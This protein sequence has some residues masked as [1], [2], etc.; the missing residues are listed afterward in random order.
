MKWATD[1]LKIFSIYLL[2]I[3]AGVIIYSIKEREKIIPNLVE[4]F[5]EWWVVIKKVSIFLIIIFILLL[6]ISI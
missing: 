2:I 3:V 5:G 4:F 6:S 1:E